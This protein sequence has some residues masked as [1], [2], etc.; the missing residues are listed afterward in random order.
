M[1]SSSPELIGLAST[2]PKIGDLR[3]LLGFTDQ[4]S[5]S[6][7]IFNDKLRAFR[8]EY[9]TADGLAG[10]DL[11]DWKSQEHQKELTLMVR[12]FLSNNNDGKDFWPGDQDT[13]NSQPSDGS[14]RNLSYHDDES[15]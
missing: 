8:R 4:S 15:L 9:K 3:K 14:S 5:P 10:V 11:H 12:S 13:N 1:S 7:K 6:S 2:I